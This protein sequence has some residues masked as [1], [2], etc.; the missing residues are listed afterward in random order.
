MLQK[1][2]HDKNFELE[3]EGY[4]WFVDLAEWVDFEKHQGKLIVYRAYGDNKPK[5][6][7]RA[8]AIESHNRALNHLLNRL[9]EFDLR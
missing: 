4:V 9:N 7:F 2:R 8:L 5:I 3:S 1:V 6:L